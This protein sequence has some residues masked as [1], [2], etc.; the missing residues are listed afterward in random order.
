MKDYVFLIV[1]GFGGDISEI[2]YLYQFLLENGLN[3]DTVLL[4][5]HGKSKK[6]LR[7]STP[8]DWINSVEE[9]INLLALQYENIVLIGFSAG[10]LICT[11]FTHIKHIK[12][13][14]F[15][16]T[17]VYFWNIRVISKD[18]FASLKEKNF[19]QI[20]YY[21]NSLLGTSLKSGVDF[22]KLLY[23]SKKLFIKIKTP[24]LILQCKNDESVRH[25]SAEYI[26]NRAKSSKVILYD[27]G[28][29]QIFSKSPELRDRVCCDIYRFLV[30]DRTCFL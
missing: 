25:R 16:N 9:K 11:H 2:D 27:G 20:K 3:A 10:G 29:H 21:R 17:P 14:V 26:N 22:L 15:I 23:S 13:I 30:N 28:C 19:E 24:L 1:H 18:I 7:K 4:S 5:G 12:K 6:D 8:E